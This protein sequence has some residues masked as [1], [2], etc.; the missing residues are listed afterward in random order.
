MRSN[1]TQFLSINND[2]VKQKTHIKGFS[3]DVFEAAVR[4]L[5]H[6]ITYKF[7]PFD[8]SS[9]ELINKVAYETFDVA[10]GDIVTTAGHN[11]HVE[12]S[13]PYLEPGFMMVVRAKT[14]ELNNFWLFLTPFTPQ[15]WVMIAAFYVLLGTITWI[16]EGQ[17]EDGPNFLEAL[18]FL[19]RRPAK[20]IGSRIV[21]NVWIF[22]VL[23]LTQVYTNM[24]TTM[25]TSS[26]Q[27]EPSISNV[28]SLRQANAT[29]GCNG[30]SQTIWLLLKVLEFKQRNITIASMNDYEEALSSGSIKAAFILTPYAKVFLAKHCAHFTEIKSTHHENLGNFGFVMI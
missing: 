19:Q 13:L 29:I 2:D 24:I 14:D 1:I 21:I 6:Q 20:N 26:Q 25:L 3:V 11:Q 4:L 15:L 9:D 16:I 17:Y 22:M 8:V 7:T 23:I 27:G 30:Q 10:I 12:F 28:D 18:F 5:P